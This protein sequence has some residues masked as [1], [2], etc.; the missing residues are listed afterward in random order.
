MSIHQLCNQYFKILFFNHNNKNKVSIFDKNGNKICLVN[1]TNYNINK[2]WSF[3][4]KLNF[5]DIINK[6]TVCDSIQN[7]ENEDVLE[8]WHRR[9]GHFNIEK[10]KD[11][12]PNIKLNNKCKV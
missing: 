2:I 7:I 5:K 1:S 4:N 10:I 9:L 3:K 6:Y 12:L 8:L 11:R